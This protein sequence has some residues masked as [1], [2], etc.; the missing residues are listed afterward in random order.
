MKENKLVNETDLY[1]ANMFN[2]LYEKLT[3]LENKKITFCLIE[4]KTI[5]TF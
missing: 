4:R 5:I 3:F 2:F 1:L